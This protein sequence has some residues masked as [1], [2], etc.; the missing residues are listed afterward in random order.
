MIYCLKEDTMEIIFN[1]TQRTIAEQK[2]INGNK[3]EYD[4][5]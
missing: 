1:W 5:K 4:N 2:S 3:N